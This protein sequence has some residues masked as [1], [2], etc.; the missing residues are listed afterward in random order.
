M[1]QGNG[2]ALSAVVASFIALILSIFVILGSI[3]DAKLLDRLY[4]LKIDFENVGSDV[5]PI[6]DHLSDY[7]K[8]QIK[9][10]KFFTVG[11]WNYCG[12]TSASTVDF[13]TKRS[14]RYHFNLQ[15]IV[16][17]I[18]RIWLDVNQPGNLASL[19]DSIIKLSSVMT[20]FYI[21]A[22]VAT[23]LAI[24]CG[25]VS[26]W[27]YRKTK[28]ITCFFAIPATA[29]HLVATGILASM[30]LALRNSIN[31]ANTSITASLGPA[32]YSIAIVS[33]VLS[34]IAMFLFIIAVFRTPRRSS[35]R[36]EGQPFLADIPLTERSG[37]KSGPV[38]DDDPF[39]NQNG[40]APHTI[41]YTERRQDD[42]YV[43]DNG[44]G[45][46]P[47]QSNQS[48]YGYSYPTT[49]YDP[50]HEVSHAR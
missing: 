10:Y 44:H 2:F 27:K 45:L 46:H 7:E 47:E 48:N 5:I 33:L 1:K 35:M 36:P 4:F 22:V 50:V 30:Y 11:L 17:R 12:W 49:A 23:A 42:P 15:D 8:D 38:D 21:V 18:T 14:R 13:C 26:L 6:I 3:T 9:K 37:H 29:C 43:A 31:N 32:L 16:Y 24:I 40:L 39:S 34:I 25:L 20:A 28:I 41:P 19:S